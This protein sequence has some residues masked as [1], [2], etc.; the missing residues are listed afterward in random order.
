[1]LSKL[2]AHTDLLTKGLDVAARRQEVI[3]HNIA[4]AETP[5]YKA[6]RVEFED[7]F[8]EALDNGNRFEAWRTHEKHIA[9][10]DP[11]PEDVVG[12][13]VTDYQ[14]TMRMDG[15]N[16]DVDAEMTRLAKNTIQYNLTITKLNAEL[17]R[18]RYAVREGR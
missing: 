4:N 14:T 11:G 12:T 17:S 3:A 9:F 15:N 5:D 6:S 2:F 1:M 8:Q 18:L 16:V 13:T 10:G 7:A